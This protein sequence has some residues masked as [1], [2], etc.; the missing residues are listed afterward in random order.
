MDSSII[1]YQQQTTGWLSEP[2]HVLVL[3]NL[4]TVLAVTP[5]SMGAVSYRRARFQVELGHAH[6]MEMSM[7]ICC[8]YGL[9]ILPT[10]RNILWCCAI[11]ARNKERENGLV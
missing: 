10:G 3:P 11:Y 8:A 5:T 1:S 9:S 6:I 4:C 2:N 7:V